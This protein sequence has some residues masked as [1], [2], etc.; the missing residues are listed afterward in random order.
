MLT[1]FKKKQECQYLSIRQRSWSVWGSLC[2]CWSIALRC[3]IHA[4]ILTCYAEKYAANLEYRS[5]TFNEA[6][7]KYNLSVYFV[8]PF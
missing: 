5:L 4:L 6:Y 2:L 1:L 7:V 3:Q 8:N